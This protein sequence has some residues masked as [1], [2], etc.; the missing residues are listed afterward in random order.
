MPLTLS[1]TRLPVASVPSTNSSLQGN[2]LSLTL[3]QLGA[4]NLMVNSKSAV[5]T[6][7]PTKAPG[8]HPAEQYLPVCIA[9][10]LKLLHDNQTKC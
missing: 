7:K 3:L 8:G 1:Y 2:F 9:L 6:S 5:Q 4:S 10:P